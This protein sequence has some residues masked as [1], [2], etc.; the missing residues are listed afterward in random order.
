MIDLS[1]PEKIHPLAVA[2]AKLYH[3]GKRSFADTA[4]A[5]IE[6]RIDALAADLQEVLGALSGLGALAMYLK[7]QGDVRACAALERLIRKQAHRFDGIRDR[8]PVHAQDRAE[9]IT[10]AFHKLAMSSVSPRRAA[11]IDSPAPEGTI[12]LRTLAPRRRI[13]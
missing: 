6:S 1:T 2:A 4:L 10:A 7:A 9:A 12:S 11:R 13:R 8:L 3:A 5:E